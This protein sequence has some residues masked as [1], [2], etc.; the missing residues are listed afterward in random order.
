[1]IQL[2][3]FTI[4]YNRRPLLEHVDATFS[5]G[6]LSALLGRNGS[7]KSTLLR[8]MAGLNHDYT[9]EIIIDGKCSAVS[10]AQRAK[11]VAF[12]NTSRLRIA[13]LKCA[14][15]V[16]LGRAPYTNWIGR[17][18]ESDR[19]IVERALQLVGMTDFAGRDISSLSD[20]EAQRVMI[21]RALAQ[22]TPV[23]LLDEPTSFLDLPNRYEVCSLLKKL[24]VERQKTIIFS[25]HELDIAL[26]I[27]DDIALIDNM[28]LIVDST[29]EI[30][31][32]GIIDRL[33][34]IPDYHLR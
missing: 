29:R 7:G 26:R 18:Q 13:N 24:T 1:M 23:I 21:A 15:V 10:P 25:T 9:G 14:D 27:A 17:M 33:F 31:S 5:R 8:A 2:K 22:D 30:E 34:A 4:G 32:S 19:D 16:A 6:R 11:T 28:Q 3:D 12:V 20:G